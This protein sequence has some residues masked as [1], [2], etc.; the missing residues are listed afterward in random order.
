MKT[1]IVTLVSLLS[2][3]V[4]SQS[5]DYMM[6]VKMTPISECDRPDFDLSMLRAIHRIESERYAELYPQYETE[7]LQSVDSLQFMTRKLIQASDCKCES[8]TQYVPY[9]NSL[10]KLVN[11]NE[12]LR[13][14]LKRI[15]TVDIIH[16]LENG[17][18]TDSYMVSGYKYPVV[19]LLTDELQN[20]S[21]IYVINHNK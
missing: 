17:V 13:S 20:E 6:R 2:V 4:Y 11:G 8:L 1:L 12:E 15:F 5:N 10:D 21:Q 7:I 14:I 19:K 3:A 18:K 16:T 9:G